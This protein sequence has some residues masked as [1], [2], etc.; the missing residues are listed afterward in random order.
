MPG[1][2]P[3]VGASSRRD[4]LPDGCITGKTNGGMQQAVKP[5]SPGLSRR[6]ERAGIPI[7]TLCGAATSG[8]STAGPMCTPAGLEM[9]R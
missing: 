8:T 4:E 9:V 1:S 2:E 5:E 6:R 3:T 7:P